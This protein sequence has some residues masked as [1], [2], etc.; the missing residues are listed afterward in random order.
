MPA[1]IFITAAEYSGDQHASL[2]ARE[3]RRLAPDVVI[4]G[5]GGPLMAAAGV[6]IRAETTRRAA[7]SLA[8]VGRVAEMWRLVRWTARYFAEHR[9]DLLICVD[10]PALNFHFARAARAA[11]MPVLYYIA[12]QVWAWRE[13]RVRKL[14]RRVDR[15]ACIL[16]FEEE[17]FR[18]H[19]VNATFV[20]HPLFDELPPR[21]PRPVEGRS[22]Q[23]P[24]VIGLLPG[25]RAAEAAAN[26][27][28][29]LRVADAVSAAFPSARYLVPTT[30]ATD[31]LVRRLSHGRRDIEAGEGR[32]NEYVSAC[33]LCIAVSGTATLHVAAL[34]TPM[35]V[36]YRG[37]PL[38]WH[39]VGRWI[40]KTRTF[41]L[42]NI[43]ARPAEPVVP[44]FIPWYGSTRP[45]SDLAI[46]YLRRPEML[47]QQAQRLAEVV[48]PLEKPGASARTAML[49]MELLGR[50][51]DAAGGGAAAAGG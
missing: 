23:R 34:G 10:S 22:P 46:R 4:E 50:R 19:G 36:V 12:P 1:R 25:S 21:P 35:I 11:G 20:G 15:L 51:A 49:A 27:P 5:H 28:R 6:A 33:D 39:L 40:I 47:Q 9:P 42:V 26:Y 31:P 30:A 38:A 29:M 41:A 24:P 7:M 14:R 44:E 13:G 48:R 17:Y 8:A 45:V 32:F 18:R 3:L 43:L 37:S 16:P 2:L